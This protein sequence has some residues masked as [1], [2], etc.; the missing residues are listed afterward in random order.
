MQCEPL[1]SGTYAV[2]AWRPICGSAAALSQVDV[3][4]RRRPMK[5]RRESLFL[6]CVLAFAFQLMATG[7]AS[8]YFVT[9]AAQAECDTTT[10]ALSITYTAGSWS[11]TLAA[12]NS[13]I[14]V[15]FNNVIVDSQAF[16]L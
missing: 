11:D 9:I 12:T 3:L 14:D 13:R 2:P 15:L 7:T 4:Q 16:E 8:A 5:V 1:P 10:G 6:S